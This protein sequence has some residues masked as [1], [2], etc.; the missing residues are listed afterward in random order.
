MEEITYHI[1]NWTIVKLLGGL[2]GILLTGFGFIFVLLQNRLLDR[3]RHSDQKEIEALRGMIDRNN[4]VLT[5]VLSKTLPDR[6]VEKRLG[7]LETIWNFVIATK[8]KPP[9]VISLMYSILG[10]EELTI[11]NVRKM[12]K[13][14]LEKLDVDGTLMKS[15]M[16][17]EHASLRYL[18]PPKLWSIAFVYQAIVN[19]SAYLAIDGLRRGKFIYWKNDTGMKAMLEN[20]LDKTEI[21]Y[22][23]N[24]Q[25]QTYDTVLNL[26]EHKILTE[27]NRIISG[28]TDSEDSVKVVKRIGDLTRKE[29]ATEQST[30]LGNTK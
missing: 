8:N 12:S 5:T 4:S 2:S 7:A 18:I 16:L 28:E 11:E 26:L 25:F 27:M 17:L 9:A 14:T 30:G 1:D 29:N 24:L 22:V 20:V 3:W 10:D 15:P 13:G 19:R 23:Y 21:D 6:F